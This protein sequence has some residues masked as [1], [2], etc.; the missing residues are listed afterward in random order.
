M[1]QWQ[2]WKLLKQELTGTSP[3]LLR[4]RLSLHKQFVIVFIYYEHAYTQ[5]PLGSF[6]RESLE[7][8][9]SVQTKALAKLRRLEESLLTPPEDVRA[10]P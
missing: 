8:E 3:G 1:R 9:P 7:M 10:P 4:R 5:M 6:S 2:L